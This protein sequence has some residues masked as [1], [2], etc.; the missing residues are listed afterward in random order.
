MR[1]PPAA[2]WAVLGETGDPVPGEPDTVACLGQDLRTI[3]DALTR[4]ADEI[5]A[6]SSV[7]TWKSPAADKF[8]DTAGE[9]V[10]NLRKAFHRYD[11]AADAVGTTVIEGSEENWA[12]ALETAQQAAAKALRDAQAA[13]D[14]HRALQQQ[15]DQLPPNTPPDDPTARSLHNR[16][17]A[18]SDALGKAKREL[19]AAKDLRDR[20][21]QHAV[22]RIR[23]AI[24]HDGLTD[25]FWDEVGEVVDDVVSVAGDVLSAVGNFLE[26]L[27][28]T[29]A[30]ILQV[31]F[32]PQ[33]LLGMAET[34]G[35]LFLM[36]LGAGG[37][38]GGFALDLTVVGGVIGVPVNVLSAGVMAGGG[39]LAYEGL[40]TWMAAMANGD[41]NAWPR[42][43][44]KGPQP[45][46]PREAD[47]L[48]DEGYGGH[49][50]TKHV[51]R[52]DQQLGDRLANE[53]AVQ[54]ASTYENLGDAQKFSQQTINANKQQISN[55]LNNAKTGSTKEFDLADTGEVTGRSMS[56]S[57]WQNGLGS[58]PVHGARVVLRADPDAPGG[59]YILTTFPY[60]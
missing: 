48:G 53:P 46:Q 4:R 43:S 39:A 55:W 3:A 40:H 18:Q 32:S 33:S 42:S 24:D 36:V 57:D 25:G 50:V 8:R 45:P 21:E 59:Y 29:L 26:D 54:D 9:T 56:R 6:L 41:Y 2:E 47:P 5:Q 20:A 49:G 60:G 13:D 14:E 23:H 34:V 44:R 31:L 37:E 52:S 58:K 38:V 19:Q 17:S 7:E 15:L 22:D 28:Y 30:N 10:Q 16:Q 27:G 51:G 1:R 12:S 11:E 35:G